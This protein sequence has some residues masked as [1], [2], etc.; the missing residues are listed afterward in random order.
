MADQKT[1]LSRLDALVADLAALPGESAP[2]DLARSRLG[3]IR[4]FVLAHFAVEEG[5][6]LQAHMDAK[7]AAEAAAKNREQG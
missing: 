2:L 7:L 5:R 1:I 4:S 3:D 6:A